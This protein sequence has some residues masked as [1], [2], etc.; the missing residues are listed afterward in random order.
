MQEK[1]MHEGKEVK[2]EEKMFDKIVK[3]KKSTSLRNKII[4]ALAVV[5]I[6]V[7]G[8]YLCF[9]KLFVFKKLVVVDA[10]T[11]K[12][13]TTPYS[14]EELCNGMGL[15]KG[16]K[17]FSKSEKDIV[18]EAK[19]NLTYIKDIEISR[20][21]PN[22]YVAEVK[23]AKERFYLSINGTIYI[24]SDDLTVLESGNSVSE[25]RIEN[26]ILLRLSSVKGCVTGEK[27]KIDEETEKILLELTGVLETEKA[28]GNIRMIDLCDKFDISLQYGTKFYVKL[29]D[30][31]DFGNKIKMMNEIIKDKAGTTAS[32]TIDVVKDFG[33]TGTLKKF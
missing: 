20:K 11:G 13:I 21:L 32:G 6:I 2:T 4:A 22:T 15:K 29:G 12:Q 25:N 27:L 18:N 10:D 26:L 23:L 17:L 28:L 24:L 31:K 5:V 16:M 7:L 8:V 33:K 30:F 19:Y 1:R 9:D 3:K 14:Q